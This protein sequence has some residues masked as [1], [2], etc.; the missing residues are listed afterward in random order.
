MG[1][2]IPSEVTWLFPI[3]VGQSWPE[4]DETALRGMADAYRAAAEGVQGVIDQG[5]G[6]AS[7]VVA[8]QVGE[9]AVAFQEYW[10]KFSDGDESYLPK[11]K[12]ICEQ[13]AESCDGTA[14]EVEYT[15][16]S[17]IASL[18]A[19]AIEIAALIAA[20]FATFGTASAGIPIAQQA[21]RLIV[22]FTFR[23]LIIAILKEVAISVGIDAAIQGIQMLSGERKDWDWG[24]TGEAAISGAVSG[25]VGGVSGGLKFEGGGIAGQVAVGATRGATEG[26]VSSVGTSVAMGQDIS[27]RDVLLGATSGAVSGSIGG[28]KDGITVEPPR[29]NPGGPGGGPPDLGPGTGGG[30][31]DL[32]PN[33]SGAGN[34]T[35]PGG[36]SNGT[37]PDGGTPGGG[38]NG[39]PP[40]GAPGGA[41]GGGSPGGGAPGGSP[42]PAGGGTPDAPTAPRPH[43]DTTSASTV[44]APPAPGVPAPT[45][46]AAG[47][48][49][50]RAPTPTPSPTFAPTGGTPAAGGPAPAGGA[51]PSSVSSRLGAPTAPGLGGPTP[52]GSSPTPGSGGTTPGSAGTPSGSPTPGSGGTSP[53][54]AGTPNGPTPGNSGSTGSTPGGPTPGSSGPTPGGPAP[55]GSAPAGSTPGGSTPG[56]PTPGGATPGGSTAGGATPGG[57]TPGSPTPGGTGSSGGPTP[58]GASPTPGSSGGSPTPGSSAPAPGGS[59]APGAGGPTPGSPGGSPAPGASGPAPAGSHVPGGPTPGAGS[60]ATP[61]AS[62]PVPAGSPASGSSGP[63]P[64][65][66]SHAAPGGPAPAGSHVPGGPTP[67]AGAPGSHAAP[68]G[69]SP[70]P[71]GAPGGF[72]AAP[73]AGP[74]P[75]ASGAAPHSTPAP[76]GF[77]P[78]PGGTAP[79]SGPDNQ[80]GFVPPAGGRGP[81]MSGGLFTDPTRPSHTTDAVGASSATSVAPQA[82]HNPAPQHAGSEPRGP[83]PGGF[84][85]SPS[86]FGPQPGGFGPQ[87]GG[88]APQHAGPSAP[89]GPA[90]TRPDAPMARTDAPARTPD[91]RIPDSRPSD[92]RTPDSRIPDTRTPDPRT[93]G[94]PDGRTPATPDSR[95]G[96]PESRPGTPDSRPATPDGRQGTPD[97][98]PGTPDPR[99]GTPDAHQHPTTTPDPT[100]TPNPDGSSP[101]SS[102]QWP[103]DPAPASRGTE[104]GPSADPATDPHKNVWGNPT[105]VVPGFSQDG[106]YVPVHESTG[107]GDREVGTYDQRVA[108]IVEPTYQPYGPHGTFDEFMRHHTTDGT[109]D[110]PIAWPPNQGA[111]G[112]RVI[113]E[114]PAGTVLDRFGSPQGDFLSPLRPDGQPYGFGERAILPDSMGKGYHVYVLDRPMLVELATVAPAFDQPGGAR[115]LQPVF[116]PSLADATGRVNL[117]S[118]REAGVLHEVPSPPPNGR[119]LPPD[120]GTVGPDG[121]T[122]LTPDTAS[123][124]DAQNG[125][126]DGTP[127]DATPA[128]TGPTPL[129]DVSPRVEQA[130]RSS[131]V[132]PAGVALHAE[133]PLRDL[134]SR[135]PAGDHAVVDVHTAGDGV[136]IG[137]T[138]YTRAELV[139]LINNHPDL[140]GRPIVLVGCDAAAGG[141]NSLAAHVAR[142]TG[143]QVIAPDSLAWSD[144]HGNVY[145]SSPETTN[146]QQ[147]PRIPPDG[148]WHAFDP[149]GTSTPV[150]E[151]G[152]PPGRTPTG[153]LADSIDAEHRGDTDR[154][155]HPQVQTPWTEPTTSYEQTVR[156]PDG[157]SLFDGRELPLDTRIEVLDESGQLR[158]VVHVDAEGAVSVDA[159]APN[160]RDGVNPEIAHPHPDADYRVQVGN[161]NDVFVAGSDGSPLTQDDKVKIG[162]RQVD[163]TR[164]VTITEPPAP[165]NGE[166]TI[167][168]GDPM[169]PRPGEAFTARTDLPPNTRFDVTDTEGNHR[170]TVQT[171]ENGTPRWV[172][173]PE[174]AGGRPNPEVANPIPGSNYNVDRGPLF[175]EFSTDAQG[176]PEPGV[177]YERPATTHRVEVTDL[178]QNRPLTQHDGQPLAADTEYVVTDGER[179]RGRVFVDD[180]GFSHVETDSGQRGRLNPEMARAPEGADITTDPYYGTGAATTPTWP[181]PPNGEVRLTQEVVLGDNGKP[182][183]DADNQVVRVVRVDGDTS[184]W[185]PEQV[186]AVERPV[187]PNDPFVTRDLPPGT[188]FVLTDERGPYSTFQSGGDGAV[189]HVHTAPPFSAELNNPR[190]TAVYDV[191][192]GRWKFLTD[193]RSNTIA[194]SGTPVYDGGTEL[195]RDTTS[196]TDAGALAGKGPDNR[197]I[198]DG[199]H[200]Q[201]K[202]SGG[203]GELINVSSQQRDQNSGLERPAFVREE[204]WYQMER[205]RAD[206]EAAS[207]G[208]IELVDTFAIREPGQD[209][210]HTYQT[211]WRETLPDGRFKIHVRSYPNDHNAALWPSDF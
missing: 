205:D 105:G 211:R 49:P 2:E 91:P 120:F 134:S 210:P 142:E 93:P 88:P 137:E 165:A 169:A 59:P 131:E 36:G 145:S 75:G 106:P 115:Q 168:P 74:T 15:K 14:L 77:A 175:Q 18:I 83:Q 45:P 4:G 209:H 197:N 87:P 119:V 103:Q 98:R 58:G 73:A 11:L 180:S 17:I 164:P 129:G 198:A 118:L 152:M 40:G 108:S 107:P 174:N 147:G 110:G 90:H 121:S 3:V 112:A 163:V 203:P 160:T 81:A 66:G 143:Q 207:G 51:A 52:G 60:P 157:Q 48:T 187:R 128:P 172:A 111:V 61:G 116:D 124:A 102:H 148:G 38:S 31:P 97:G 208:S 29:I 41:P 95:P 55:A 184:G 182:L 173:A 136:R 20:A 34:G 56:G 195:R 125:A 64:G 8:S 44:A 114:L 139:E 150:G 100:S 94:T 178:P 33:P 162:G 156:L 53:G 6:A 126:F 176:R 167:H 109:V 99:P 201:G 144:R 69:F 32:G 71:N 80:G 138:H 161:R 104:P 171:D 37:P 166:R 76:G 140:A 154:N 185:T 70:V 43:T 132:T 117:D 28:A 57:S 183:R 16:L 192:S 135:I 79:G 63:M 202:E 21:T 186:A 62:G 155:H 200:H 113:V 188:R 85:P 130:I 23:Q 26:A 50:D 151:N 96:A 68:G 39:T 24:K 92:P 158:S 179:V 78:T 86:G 10:K 149:D 196:Q 7:T 181:D 82:F 193:D 141:E 122:V 1:I 89:T 206:L 27:A 84:T 25:L 35:P 65:T 146:G 204:T 5:N 123:V 133:A 72:H 12:K 194:T 170:G 22:Q 67:G 199:G 153:D 13:L 30:P 42:A 101:V 19:L 46:S 54:S 190:P 127:A 47:N 191:D 159:I 189:S 177:T 9:A